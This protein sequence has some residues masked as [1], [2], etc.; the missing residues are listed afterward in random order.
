MS[1][2]KIEELWDSVDESLHP[3]LTHIT[4]IDILS[5]ELIESERALTEM[6]RRLQRRFHIVDQQNI[7]ISGLTG[8]PPP[9]ELGERISEINESIRQSEHMGVWR[10]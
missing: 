5:V 7:L 9:R 2:S 6:L 8:E 10:K 1:C 3:H 4:T